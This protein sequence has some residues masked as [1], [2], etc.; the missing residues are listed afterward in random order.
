MGSTASRMHAVFRF[1]PFE[2]S[3]RDGELRKNGVRIK[4]QEQP[5][6]VLVELLAN[7]GTVVT[8]EELQ[9]KVW[10][11]DTFVDFDV[12]LNTAIRKIRQALGD[13]ADDPHYIETAAKRGYRFL[14]PVSKTAGDSVLVNGSAPAPAASVPVTPL[15]LETQT[16][17]RLTAHSKYLRW[18]LLLLALAAVAVAVTMVI[19]IK[20]RMPQPEIKSLAVLPLKNLSGDPAQEYLADGMTEEL[21]GRL[22][23]IHDLRVISRTSV[24][25]FKDTRLSVPEI[26]KILGVDAVVEGSVIRDGNRIRVHAQLIRGITDNPFWSQTYDR[27]IRDVLTL[28][29]E[30]TQAIADQVRVQL[31]PKQQA[32]L[33]SARE[34]NPDAYDAYLKGRFFLQTPTLQA[35]KSAESYF[36]EAIQKDSTFALA[37]AGLADCYLNS[38]DYR[39]VRPQEAYRLGNEA[40]QNAM[41]L[42]ETLSEVH[43][44]FGRLHWR[45]DWDW[46]A[47]EKEFRYALEL[48]ANNTNAREGLIWYLAWSGRQ[49]EALDELGRIRTADPAYPLVGLDESGIYYHARHYTALTE[50]SRKAL[51]W[52]P[53][54]WSGHYFL[55]VSYDGLGRHAEAIPEYEKAVEL[56]QGNT[57]AVA[58]LVHAYALVGERSGATKILRQLQERSG[59]NYV[60]PYMLA[61]IYTA[62][63]D[64]NRA[65]AFLEKSY[66][67]RSPDIAYFLKADLRLDP[68]RSEPRFLDLLRRVGLN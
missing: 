15:Q 66:Q 19:L 27:E 5:F 38:G 40:I 48:N 64:K 45:Y 59:S 41:R 50:A 25:R 9:Q 53:N 49:A 22:A 33:R 58:G 44:S 2:L 12:G 37:Y 61:T 14:A 60:S 56:S 16:G 20:L 17:E 6:R 4:L 51:S 35:N 11:A 23:G 3:E 57:D 18:Y 42:D 1:G 63:G 55:A 39:W 67:E 34:V 43:S 28:E 26:A 24:M 10:P 8:R 21:I 47:A 32:R 30:A 52:D 31:S 62:L 46:Q 68:L 7:A 65:Y 54:N 29:S 36:Q 13:E